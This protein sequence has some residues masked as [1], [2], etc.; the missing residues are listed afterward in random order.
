M[1]VWRVELPSTELAYGRSELDTKLA[2]VWSEL[3]SGWL[4]PV[5]FALQLY[6]RVVLVRDSWEGFRCRA[7]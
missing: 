1:K 6:R 3:G 7:G 5:V 2:L 4:K